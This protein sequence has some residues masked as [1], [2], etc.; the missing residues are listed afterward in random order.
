MRERERERGRKNGRQKKQR[1]RKR[2][3]VRKCKHSRF[4]LVS[5]ILSKETKF[6]V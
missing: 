4:A 5:V 1:G 3:E 6:M 2:K